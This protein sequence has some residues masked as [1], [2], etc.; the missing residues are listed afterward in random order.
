[1]SNVVYLGSDHAGFAAKEKI[2]TWL[3]SNGLV[4]ID[5]GTTNE[6]SCHYPDY[7]KAVATKVL[8]NKNSRGILLCGS[9]FGVDMVANRF[10]GIRAA[11]CLS[12]EDARLSR[13]HN[14]ANVL[15][16][17]ARLI[18]IETLEKITK[19]WLNSPFEGGRHQLRI[20]MF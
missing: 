5:V 16:L 6:A 1:M 13:S 10:V 18:E 12:E 4:V 15:C 17:A 8:E 19:T 20:E 2:K 11:R 14:D 7:A 3:Q 9:G